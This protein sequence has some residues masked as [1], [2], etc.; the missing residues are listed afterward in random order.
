MQIADLII[1]EG[2]AP[3]IAFSKWDLTEDRQMVLADLYEKTARGFC[4][5]CAGFRAV[6]I[7][8]ER[9]Q[10]IDKLMENV[11]KTH[12]IWNRRI[13]TGPPQPWLEGV[14]AHQRRLPFPGRRL[15]VKYGAGEDPPPGFVV[16]LFAA[17]RHAA[18]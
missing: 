2:R 17:R 4:R 11:V 12:E 1:R 16:S 10:G 7:S 5:R 15:K 8:G 3:V 13:S 14:I 6:A 18:I 9:G